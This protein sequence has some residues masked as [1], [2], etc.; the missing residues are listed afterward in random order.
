MQYIP[1]L[2]ARE[3]EENHRYFKERVSL[4]KEKG[5]DFFESRKFILEKAKPLKGSILEIGTGS[6]Y[7]TLALAKAGYKIISVDKDKEALK[8][9]ALNLAHVNVL[10]SVKFH[11]MDGKHLTFRNSSFNNVVAVNLFHHI[12]SANKMFAEIDRILYVNGKIILAD[13]NKRGM[14]TV[15]AVHKQ[16]GRVHE[17]KF[18]TKA[19]V[20]S[21]FY[22]LGYD[23]KSFE[24]RCHWVLIGTKLIQE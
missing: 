1:K 5:L 2:S 9:A 17:N 15:D 16:E 22:G 7:T 20:S 4:Y 14:E 19:N 3:V 10:S 12:D 21:H 23:I 24:T 6:G 13:F 11:V 8:A 18:I